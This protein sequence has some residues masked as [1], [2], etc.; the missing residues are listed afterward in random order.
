MGTPSLGGEWGGWGE[1]E[2]ELGP[3]YFRILM[4]G[5]GGGV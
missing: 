2:G 4:L 1:G 3:G 5:G